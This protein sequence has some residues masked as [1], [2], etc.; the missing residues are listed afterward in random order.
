MGFNV[1]G[2]R[3]TR[4]GVW[5]AVAGTAAAAC[6]GLAVAAPAQAAGGYD[7]VVTDVRPVLA[8]VQATGSRVLFQATIR[9]AGTVA[10]PAGVVHGV[11]FAVNGRTVSWA[12]TSTGAL[13]AGASRTVTATGGPAGSATWTAV[14]GASTLTATVDDVNRLPKELDE[15]NNTRSAALSATPVKPVTGLTVKPGLTQAQFQAT[16]AKTL[17]AS[18]QVPAGQPVGVS[19]AVTEVPVDDYCA[20]SPTAAKGSAAASSL[21]FDMTAG[22]QCGTRVWVLNDRYTVTAVGPAG[23]APVSTAGSQTCTWSEYDDHYFHHQVTDQLGCD[24]QAQLVDFVDPSWALVDAGAAPSLGWE[25]DSGY[26]KG[27]VFTSTLPGLTPQEASVRWGWSRYTAA[28]NSASSTGSP[29]LVRLTFVEPTFGARGQ[30]VFDVSVN[31]RL[32]ADDLDIFAKVG[33]GKPYVLET[34]VDNPGDL[35][36]I[37]AQ[38]SRDNPIV[39]TVEVKAY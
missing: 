22:Q 38:A 34:L 25:G 31:G 33:R 29:W 39:S 18:W 19:Y 1:G 17:T 15:R 11:A 2:R 26:D 5:G 37:T 9:N 7:L 13:A 21:T 35:V 24:G 36:Q 10:T 32:V 20:E 4:R 23:A 3:G 27:Q 6:A 12:D 14:T 28:I 8:G 30:R 16:H